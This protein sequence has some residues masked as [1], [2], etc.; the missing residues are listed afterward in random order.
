MSNQARKTFYA[1]ARDIIRKIA[2]DVGGG[3]MILQYTKPVV[4]TS[5]EKIVFSW[6]LSYDSH[7]ETFPQDIARC[8]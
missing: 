5:E 3:K 1:Q 7:Y 4:E 6:N 2:E 8:L